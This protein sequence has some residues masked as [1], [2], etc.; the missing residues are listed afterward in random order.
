MTVTQYINF[1]ICALQEQFSSEL[2]P[3]SVL[4]CLYGHLKPYRENQSTE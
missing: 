4:L 2:P 1:F 3:A